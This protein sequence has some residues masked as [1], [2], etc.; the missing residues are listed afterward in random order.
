MLKIISYLASILLIFSLIILITGYFSNPNFNGE[1]EW[2]VDYSREIVWDI[3]VDIEKVPEKKRDVENVEIIGKYFD[4]YAWRENLRS[5]GFRKYRMVEVDEPRY[6]KLELTE[7]S[8]QMT[9]FWEFTLTEDGGVTTIKIRE[10]SKLDSVWKRG[11]QFYLGRDFE[12]N[13][14]ARYVRSGLFDRLLSTS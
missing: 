14:W 13:A 3:L 10:E 9:G 2:S 5:D 4:L 12:L 11:V 1:T 7:S 8:Y 6:L